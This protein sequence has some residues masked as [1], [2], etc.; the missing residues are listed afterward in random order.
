MRSAGDRD[1]HQDSTF[2]RGDR[3]VQVPQADVDPESAQRGLQI[4]I[5]KG[6]CNTCH[7]GPGRHEGIKKLLSS[8][9]NLLGKYSDDVA[10]S[11]ATW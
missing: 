7:V 5:G 4:F 3:A 6:S 2:C 1:G 10:R 8:R 11:S 9:Y